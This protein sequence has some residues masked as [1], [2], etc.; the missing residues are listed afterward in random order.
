MMALIFSEEMS[1]ESLSLDE[2]GIELVN[3]NE[4]DNDSDEDPTYGEKW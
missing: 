4:S 3:D 1:F 2:Y